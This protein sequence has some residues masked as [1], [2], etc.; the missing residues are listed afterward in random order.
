MIQDLIDC[1]I[2]AFMCAVCGFVYTALLTD[3]DQIFDKLHDCLYVHLKKKGH[4]K[5]FNV[6]IGCE[7][8]VSGEMALWTLVFLWLKKYLL[9]PW[10]NGQQLPNIP[11]LWIHTFYPLNSIYTISLAIF[12]AWLL[13]RF[14]TWTKRN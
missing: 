12:A 8:C 7:K 1:T 2:I 4:E 5:L 10:L 6:L 11:Q 9:F 3:P 13:N 14:Y